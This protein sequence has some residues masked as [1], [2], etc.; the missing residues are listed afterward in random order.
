MRKTDTQEK[1]RFRS[2]ER[3][4]QVNEGWWFATRDGDRGPFGSRKQAQEALV[5]YV[6][7]V[8]GH[9]DLNEV[10]ILG[11]DDSGGG[12][13]WDTRPDVIR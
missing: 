7:D 10:S 4:F 1:T 13:V 6:L 12:S 8:R 11:K 5:Q 9:I 3:I 2:P